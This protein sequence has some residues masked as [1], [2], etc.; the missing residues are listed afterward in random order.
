MKHQ[1]VV[2]DE[3][4]QYRFFRQWQESR[5]IDIKQEVEVETLKIAE[6]VKER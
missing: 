6:K 1:Q 4:R 3:R 2:E 5:L